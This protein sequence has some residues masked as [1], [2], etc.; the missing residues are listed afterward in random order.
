MLSGVFDGK[1]KATIV[2]RPQKR[3]YFQIFALRYISN[4]FFFTYPHH[5]CC[6]DLEL[7][8]IV[9]LLIRSYHDFDGA[10][11][12]FGNRVNGFI[13]SAFKNRK[14]ICKCSDL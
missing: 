8:D 2:N 3:G 9:H 7:Y 13:M 11:I 6:L 12:S 10:T 14:A 4:S 1:R 5:T